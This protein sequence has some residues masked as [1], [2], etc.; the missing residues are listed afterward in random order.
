MAGISTPAGVIFWVA[1]V[2][3]STGSHRVGHDLATEQQ[4]IMRFEEEAL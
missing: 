1:L 4:L 3:Q 2:R